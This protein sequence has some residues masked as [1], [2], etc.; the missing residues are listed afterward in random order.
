[1]RVNDRTICLDSIG[2]H[3]TTP[4]IF[5]EILHNAGTTSRPPQEPTCSSHHN[6][7][8]HTHLAFV[9]HAAKPIPPAHQGSMFNMPCLPA[10]YLPQHCC[11]AHT[12]GL[13]SFV[14]GSCCS[15]WRSA[16][17]AAVAAPGSASGAGRS[18]TSNSITPDTSSDQRTSSLPLSLDSPLMPRST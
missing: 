18:T 9:P 14:A 3:T 5:G 7:S 4:I 6:S 1:M 15:S 10:H 12:V 13:H 11:S 8:I 2:M 16:S 17:A